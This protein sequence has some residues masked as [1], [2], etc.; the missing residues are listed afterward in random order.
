MTDQFRAR[1]IETALEYFEGDFE[2]ALI[3]GDVRDIAI[4]AFVKSWSMKNS[5]LDS[6][7]YD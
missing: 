7:M 5:P 3:K 4:F 6:C 1:R 2:P